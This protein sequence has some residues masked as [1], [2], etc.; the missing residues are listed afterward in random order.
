MSDE[1]VVGHVS[2]SPDF[3]SGPP[4]KLQKLL[5]EEGVLK[6]A[7]RWSGEKLI[8][9]DLVAAEQVSFE[10]VS[11]DAAEIAAELRP[12]QGEEK[13]HKIT[14]LIGC[15]ES[16]E[17]EFTYTNWKGKT[18]QR[19]A[20]FTLL[21]FGSTEYHPKPQLLVYGYDLDKKAPRVY[22]LKDISGIKLIRDV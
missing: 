12:H 15:S 19:R 14:T 1:Q 20:V 3:K 7:P 2:W 16:V 10:P 17:V 4:D 22:A 8:S 11:D 21:Q 13:E 5:D 18:K 6:F 9:V